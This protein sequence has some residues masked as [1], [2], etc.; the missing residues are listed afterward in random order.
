MSS[1]TV[2]Y[3]FLG[4]IAILMYQIFLI[5]RDTQ[6]FKSYDNATRKL[7]QSPSGLIEL[8]PKEKFCKSQAHW[9]PDCNLE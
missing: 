1:K 3:T 9:H 8:T 7:S 5:H 6:M 2:T 4:V